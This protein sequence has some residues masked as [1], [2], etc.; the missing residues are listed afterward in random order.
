MFAHLT[1]RA[2]VAVSGADARP[3][4]DNLLSNAVEDLKPGEARLVKWANTTR[5]L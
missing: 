5:L 2:L 3:W 1:S 4:L